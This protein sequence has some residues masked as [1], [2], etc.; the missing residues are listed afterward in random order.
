LNFPRLAIVTEIKG[1]R[2]MPSR[3]Y[4][5]NL[6]YQTTEQDLR[7]LFEGAG[8]VNSVTIIMDRATNR[9]KG[10][11]FVEMA[12]EESANEAIGKFND[13]TLHNR[14]IRVD[15]AKP[16]EGGGDGG[17]RDRRPNPRGR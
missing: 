11:G 8:T 16:R 4:I 10:F 14:K 9:S 2:L 12:T 7:D 5:G 1:E 13:F 6:S 15:M 3:L 17:R